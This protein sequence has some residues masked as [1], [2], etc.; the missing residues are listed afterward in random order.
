MVKKNPHQIEIGPVI[1]G[2]FDFTHLNYNSLI[3]LYFQSYTYYNHCGVCWDL[4][5]DLEKPENILIIIPY[6]FFVTKNK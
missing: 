1:L 6:T 2:Q 3:Y 4:F 5:W